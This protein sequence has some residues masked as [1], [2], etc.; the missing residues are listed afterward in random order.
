MNELGFIEDEPAPNIG[1]LVSMCTE[2]LAGHEEYKQLFIL[3]TLSR[4]VH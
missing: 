2:Y 1:E 3:V 4:T